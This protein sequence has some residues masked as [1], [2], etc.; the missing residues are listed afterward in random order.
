MSDYVYIS[1]ETTGLE[2]KKERILKKYGKNNL[3]L[4]YPKNSKIFNDFMNFKPKEE[5]LN[6]NDYK[7]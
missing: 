3:W 2:V 5:Y 1:I 7:I 4:L 6:Y